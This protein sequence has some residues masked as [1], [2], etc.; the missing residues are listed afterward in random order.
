MKLHDLS[1]EAV[2]FGTFTAFVLLAFDVLDATTRA[3]DAAPLLAAMAPIIITLGVSVFG[4]W[5]LMI[6]ASSCAE[7]WKKRKQQAEVFLYREKESA[8]EMMREVRDYFD[9]RLSGIDPSGAKSAEELKEGV[10]TLMGELDA[11]G[12]APPA[13]ADDAEWVLLLNKLLPRVQIYGIGGARKARDA[14]YAGGKGRKFERV[15][16]P[17]QG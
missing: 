12:L 10:Q 8:T 16:Q 4:C 6:I 5:S 7:W 3:V 11:L 14:M 1:R 9:M 17:E 15:L 13:G 2:V